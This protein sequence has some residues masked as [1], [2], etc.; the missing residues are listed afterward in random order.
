[1]H[2][3]DLPLLFILAGLVFYTVLGGADFGAGIWQLTAGA[4]EG[5][6]RLRDLAHD[7]M[8]PVWEANHVWLIF[9]LTVLWTAFPT[10]FASLASTLSVPL[11]AAA[12]GLILRGAAYALR[13]GAGSVRETRRIDTLFAISSL[14][15]PF[16]LGTMVGAIASGRVPV[17][18][19][20]G[21]L[22]SSWTGATSILIGA[23]AVATSAYL[24]AVFLCDDAR[25][26]GAAELEARFRARA[27]LAGALAGVLAVGG[28]IVLHGDAHRIF[29]RLLAGPG[30]PALIVSV[31]CG[32]LALWLVWRSRFAAAR[33]LAALAVAAIVAGWALAQQPLL[34]RGLT[35]AQAAAP[36]D[37][38]VLVVIAV[39]A[40]GAILFPS[41][42][43]LFRLTL[44][45]RLGHAS[46]DDAAG[47][48]APASGRH[49]APGL[50]ARAAGAC[51]LAGVG[52]LTIADAGWAHA[53]GV[54]CL[55]GF[56]VFG[57]AAVAPTELAETGGRS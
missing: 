28:L 18:N 9:V 47:R 56:V 43:L 10:A 42:A 20:T 3:Y 55:L 54:V 13:S 22:W 38:L 45:G 2:L 15:T 14:L 39:L 35:V 51:L 12:I 31:A 33:A 17:G 34:L 19:A 11:F 16:A 50:P 8:A 30:L 4:G 52:L 5:A 48:F 29:H 36:H 53:A 44:S 41:L 46:A 26:A 23:L 57:V 40:G 21:R 37:T 32:A 7:S 24:A 25:R 1:M 49:P 6:E 27:L